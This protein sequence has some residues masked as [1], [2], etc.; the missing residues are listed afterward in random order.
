MGNLIGAT[1]LLFFIHRIYGGNIPCGEKK[2]G[3]FFL[4]IE[5]FYENCVSHF[6]I[7]ENQRGSVFFFPR[8]R[9][10]KRK[11]LFKQ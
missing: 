9:W 6:A 1:S 2:I 11:K 3:I 7:I 10:L 8:Q 4:L 5:V